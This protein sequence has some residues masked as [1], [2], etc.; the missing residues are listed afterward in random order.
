MNLEQNPRDSQVTKEVTKN[1]R[2]AAKQLRETKI[3][4]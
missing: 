2:D 3:L 4:L 1:H